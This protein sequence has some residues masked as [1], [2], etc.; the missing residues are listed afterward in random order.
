[1]LPIFQELLQGL[2]R[3]CLIHTITL[4]WLLVPSGVGT[5]VTP[6]LQIREQVT[7]R[8]NNLPR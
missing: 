8:L 3:F 2:F 7:K 4:R 1:M 6:I 5:I